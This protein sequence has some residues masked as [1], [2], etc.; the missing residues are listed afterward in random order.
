M[1]RDGFN[2]SMDFSTLEEAQQHV[3]LD[4]RRNDDALL[5]P[6]TRMD[7]GRSGHASF[8]TKT[9]PDVFESKVEAIH[10][11]KAEAATLRQRDDYLVE[12]V[13]QY[14]EH[15]DEPE[16]ESSKKRKRVADDDVEG[17]RVALSA[18]REEA[19]RR[20]TLGDHMTC[21]ECE[22][23][24]VIGA[25]TVEE[26]WHGVCPACDFTYET[27][28]LPS[29]FVDE[30]KYE[31]CTL[32]GAEDEMTFLRLKNAV[33]EAKA[34]AQRPQVLSG[35]VLALVYKEALSGHY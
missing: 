13:A 25:H 16:T 20:I 19:Y 2:Y 24:I 11:C 30:R 28:R 23:T 22:S 12:V 18:L 8:A 35:K 6:D 9:L 4:R 31:M 7:S 27:I 1:G 15:V 10:A 32:N 5:V 14:K 34:A 29:A 21:S 3:L 26:A 17:L 33:A